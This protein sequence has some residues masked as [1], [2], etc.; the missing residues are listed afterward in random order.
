MT[1]TARQSWTTNAPVMTTTRPTPSPR[2]AALECRHT[3]ACFGG[4]CTVLVADAVRPADAAAAAALGKRRLLDW[5]RRFSRFERESEISALN[6]DPRHVVPVSP[7][8]RRLVVAAVAA[9]RRTGGLVDATLGAAIAEAGYASSWDGNGIPLELALAMAPPRAPAA[10]DPQDR[11]C[12]ITVD[13]RQGIVR[14]RPGLEIDL[15]GIAKGVFADELAVMLEGFDAYA[16]DCAGD[17]RL[18][19]DGHIARDIHVESPF[20]GSVLHTFVLRGGAI[21]TSGIGRRSWLVP[22]GRPAHHLLDPRTAEPAFTGVVQATALAPSAAAAEALAKAAVLSGPDGAARWL[23]HGGVIVLDDGSYTVLEPATASSGD[24]G[25][26]S[27]SQARMSRS[28]V[29]RS[30]SLRISW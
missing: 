28:T 15:G 5:H 6:R 22:G 11:W 21:A 26:R 7:L 2:A 24:T 4:Q 30:G 14:R 9:A 20:D 18:G 29:S 1:T 27:A 12:R 25:T 19:G 10:P 16:V 8:L 3:F 13:S 17:I 23:S